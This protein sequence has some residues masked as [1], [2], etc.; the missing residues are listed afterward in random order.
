MV[1]YAY[2]SNEIMRKGALQV[3]RMVQNNLQIFSAKTSITID[4]QCSRNNYK[5]VVEGKR[6][7]DSLLLTLVC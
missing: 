6:M 1:T 7:A 2:V 5:I 3:H 4:C